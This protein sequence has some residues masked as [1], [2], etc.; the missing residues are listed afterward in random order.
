M[1]DPLSEEYLRWL[2]P[3]I[4]EEEDQVQYWD[5]VSLLY[6]KEF[7]W[8]VHHDDNRLADGMDLRIEYAYVA[9]VSRAQMKALGPC[10]F[11]EVLIGLSRRLSFAAGGSA[12]VWAWIM[13][14][15]LGLHK[16]VDPL[17]RRKVR[18]VD[19]ILDTVIG[20][21]YNPDGV[22]GFFPLAWPD[23]DMTQV[24]LWYQMAA[25]I[26]ELHPEH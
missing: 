16:M 12:P 9:G 5:L 22:G 4:R 8:T 14:G 23:D 15:N 7:V 2:A 19:D 24:E 25:Y 3:Q 21:T 6:E 10:S 26:E 11:L 13:L 20:R 1:S 18:K 17:N